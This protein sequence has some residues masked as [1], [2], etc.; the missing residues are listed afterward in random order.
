MCGLMFDSF[1][2]SKRKP[3]GT[4]DGKAD[5]CQARSLGTRQPKS[6]QEGSRSRSLEPWLTPRIAGAL[7]ACSYCC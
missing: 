5:I 6:T 4:F 1:P 3:F 7:G 2:P